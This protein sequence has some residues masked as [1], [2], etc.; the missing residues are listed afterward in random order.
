MGI[1]GIIFMP[2]YT[3]LCNKCQKKFD[4]L[5]GMTQEKAELKCIYC[6]SS[7]IVRGFSPFGI[8]AAG[9]GSASSSGCGSCSGGSC[10]TCGH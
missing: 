4:I 3:Y 5:V 8:K 2:L 7:D 10:S 1:T 9:G 6:G